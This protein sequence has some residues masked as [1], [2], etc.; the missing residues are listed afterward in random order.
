MTKENDCHPDLAELVRGTDDVLKRE[1]L[2]ERL[3]AGKTLVIKAGF[4][5]TAPDL[6]LGHTVLLNKMRQFQ[7][8][9]HEV[10]FVVGDFTARVGDPSGRSATRPTLSHDEITANAKTYADQV[11]KILDPGKT[12]LVFNSDWHDKLTST[13]LIRLAGEM[14]VARMLE[15]DDFEKRYRSN[16]PI[17]VH[18]FLYPLIQGYDSVALDADVELGGTDQRFNLLAG[19][20]LQASR[21]QTPQVVMTMPIIE[22]LDGVKKMSK[23][24]GNAIG[25]TEPPDEM[26]GK[27][28]SVSDELMW[29]YFE[30]L[31]ARPLEDLARLEKDVRTGRNPR[32]VKFLLAE[33]MVVRF[34]DEAAARKAHETF[35]ARFAKGGQPEDMPE[36]ELQAGLAM[37]QLLKAAGLVPST[38]E[39]GRMLKQGAV[40][41]DGERV[42]DRNRRLDAGTWVVQVGKRRFTRIILR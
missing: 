2:N 28:M 17:S 39:A 11:G 25:L 33:E 37:P 9:G 23:S 36:V 40:K 22:G 38:S 7:E 19:R 16:D 1:E 3:K 27:I 32:D 34:H 4:D 31:S 20:Q 18:E 30:L 14:T 6:H 10:V 41:I 15:R 35:V 29:R 5:P 8:R 42:E 26:F 13:D 21:G 24:F 12:R